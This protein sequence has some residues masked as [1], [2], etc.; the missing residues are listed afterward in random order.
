MVLAAIRSR[1]K[2][3]QKEVLEPLSGWGYLLDVGD[4]ESLLTSS[5]VYVRVGALKYAAATRRRRHLPT[6]SHYVPGLGGP[7]EKG[8][9]QDTLNA[10]KASTLF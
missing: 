8:A 3:A 6:V 1:N 7:W 2:S 5:D 10:L 9:T 4:I